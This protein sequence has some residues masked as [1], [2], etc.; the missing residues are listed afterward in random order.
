MKYRT[1]QV[2]IQVVKRRSITKAADVLGVSKSS[3]SRILT[4]VEHTWDTQLLVRSTRSI[5]VTAAGE[6]VF[7][8]F[9]RIVE[10]AKYTETLVESSLEHI[11][12]K[13]RMTSPEAFACHNLAPIIHEFSN[14]YPDVKVDLTLSSDY[15]FLI[16]DDYDLAFRIGEMEDS[17]LR[18]K[19]LK[20]SKLALF[21]SPEYIE[22]FGRPESL[23]ELPNHNCLLYKGMP[24]HSQ[25][26]RALGGT[27]LFDVDGNIYSNSELFLIEMARNGQGILLFPEY[28]LRS[29][30]NNGELE[31]ILE[32]C[33]SSICINAVYPFSQA[34]SGKLRL[35]LDFV[36]ERL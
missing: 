27:A 4:Q 28:L 14:Q 16:E 13:I 10:D 20:K 6:A 1:E 12:G 34:L 21:A 7:K 19:Q 30:L 17:Q 15:E 22:K 33:S 9:S 8:H 36:I 24:L 18:A 31:Q 25:W 23:D 26:V 29:H 5:S 35:F 2:Y 32:H 3:V 11:S